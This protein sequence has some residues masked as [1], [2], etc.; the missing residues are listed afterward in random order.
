MPPTTHSNGEVI[1]PAV[2]PALSPGG[3]LLRNLDLDVAAP[4]RRSRVSHGA[5]FSNATFHGKDWAKS[6]I[7]F[8]GTM[9]WH[10]P[11]TN[12]GEMRVFLKAAHDRLLAKAHAFCASAA[13]SWPTAS[14][15]GR[16]PGR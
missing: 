14:H 13:L 2:A 15:A 9:R 4:G 11:Q 10:G 8:R 16:A 5:A 6:T 12:A 1:E 3:M 7:P